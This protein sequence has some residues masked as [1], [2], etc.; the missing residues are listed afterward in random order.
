ML[1]RE[2]AQ[3]AAERPPAC[4]IVLPVKS[5]YSLRKPT[6]IPAKFVENLVLSSYVE[7]WLSTRKITRPRTFGP[8]RLG[9]QSVTSKAFPSLQ[10]TR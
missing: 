10:L 4:H 3:I 9:P 2:L 5:L 1:N 8:T 6:A 7:G